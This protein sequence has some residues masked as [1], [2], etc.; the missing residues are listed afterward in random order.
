MYGH[1]PDC[2][3]FWR[4]AIGLAKSIGAAGLDVE[5]RNV[6]GADEVRLVHEAGLQLAVWTVN[7]EDEAKRLTALG[8]DAI[9][10][11]R[12]AW[13]SARAASS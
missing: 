7:D 5:Y 8:V 10:S 6:T 3:E 12:A 13:L 2:G 1:S 9:T 4:T 11:D